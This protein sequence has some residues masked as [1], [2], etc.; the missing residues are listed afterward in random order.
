M[1]GEQLVLVLGAYSAFVLGAFGLL[2]KFVLETRK[3]TT[4]TNTAVNTCRGHDRSGS[5]SATLRELV[6]NIDSD[7]RQLRSESFDRHRA[8]VTR[9]DSLSFDMAVVK[10]DL[11]Q[12]MKENPGA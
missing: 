3:T 6:E 12:H 2:I 8:N 11:K 1:T 4:E 7:V 9:I 10:S 5:E